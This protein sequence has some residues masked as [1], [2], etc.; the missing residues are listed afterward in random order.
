[1]DGT[2]ADPLR[3]VLSWHEA[4]NAGDAAAAA[5]LAADDVEIAGPR[6]ATFGREALRDWVDR[7]G[8]AMTPQR[9]F[10]RGG[11]V[12]VAS[13]TTW[14]TG[15]EDADPTGVAT[16]FLVVGGAIARIARHPDVPAALADA[17]LSSGDV[18]DLP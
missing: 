14:S 9:A 6:G 15:A 12:V 10:A 16:A 4:V 8:I 2:A 7:A 18:V 17:G 11:E 1:M 5:A 3:I 13:A